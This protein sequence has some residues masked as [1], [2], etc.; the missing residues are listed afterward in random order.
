MKFLIIMTLLFS[1]QVF[2]RTSKFE[3]AKTKLTKIFDNEFSSLNKTLTE[4]NFF[5]G[6]SQNQRSMD[7]TGFEISMQASVGVE[8]PFFIEIA[9]VPEI[10]M[11]WT[12]VDEE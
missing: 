8:I 10:E 11:I 5:D 1:T 6:E 4:E 7:L 12:R 3:T 2:S 9:V